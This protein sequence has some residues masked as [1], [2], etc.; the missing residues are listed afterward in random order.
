MQKATLLLMTQDVNMANRFIQEKEEISNRYRAIRRRHLERLAPGQ[1]LDTCFFDLLNCLRRINT[2]LT[3]VA[4][5]IVRSAGGNTGTHTLGDD[6]D[7]SSLSSD[8]TG[9]HQKSL[10]PALS[11]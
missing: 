10:S 7:E 6:P 3:A 5:A 9:L 8:E 2:H 11:A 1:K 4:Y